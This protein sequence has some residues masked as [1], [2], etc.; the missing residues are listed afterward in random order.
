VLDIVQAISLSTVNEAIRRV[1]SQREIYIGWNNPNIPKIKIP[2][3]VIASP[4]DTLCSIIS[5]SDIFEILNNPKILNPIPKAIN[6]QKI[7]SRIVRSVLTILV[8]GKGIHLKK[9]ANNW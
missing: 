8:I 1:R 6:T 7:P 2:K 3:A 9:C 5:V 4:K